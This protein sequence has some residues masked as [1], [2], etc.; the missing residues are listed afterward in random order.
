MEELRKKADADKN[1]KS[2]KDLVLLLFET[3]LLTYGFSLDDPNTF[4]NRIHRMLKLGLSIYKD[5]V[6]VVALL[7]MKLCQN[8]KDIRC[9]QD[10]LIKQESYVMCMDME[11]NKDVH[12]EKRRTHQ[13]EGIYIWAFEI[14][15]IGTDSL[16]P[17]HSI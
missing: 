8:S 7:S 9:Y 6:V 2:T 10:L 14:E 4:G 16:M 13:R 5:N 12:F 1:D 3:T 17:F 15:P 11:L